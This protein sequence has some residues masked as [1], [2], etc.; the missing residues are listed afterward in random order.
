MTCIDAVHEIFEENP[1]VLTTEQVRSAIYA[2]HPDERWKPTTISCHLIGL[3]ANHPS[4]KYYPS[5]RKQAFLYSLGNGRYRR[6]N[7]S[8]DGAR[9]AMQEEDA[10]SIAV[11]DASDSEG[12]HVEVALASTAL[13]LE[14]DLE[15]CI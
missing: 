13:S 15:R 12:E 8:K 3:S 14:R 2:K 11:A 10:T 6:W 7:P 1:G 9:D 4:S 5:M